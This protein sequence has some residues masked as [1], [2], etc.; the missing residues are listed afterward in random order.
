MPCPDRVVPVDR[1]ELFVC[2]RAGEV[3]VQGTAQVF[4]LNDSWIIELRCPGR[5][6]VLTFHIPSNAP[7]LNF[8]AIDLG[9]QSG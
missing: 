3:F 7:M 6:D 9:G 8:I 1:F 2:A 5:D 4:R